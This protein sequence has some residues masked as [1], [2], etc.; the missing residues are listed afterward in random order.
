MTSFVDT[1]SRSR[2]S[3]ENILHGVVLVLALAILG[4]LAAYLSTGV[5]GAMSVAA[6]AIA[7]GI[8]APAAPADLT[9]RLYRA[10]P[11][12]RDDSQLSTIVD[13][14]SERAGLPRRPDLFVVPSLTLNA[15]SAGTSDRPA[16]A[17]SEGMLRR[18]TMREIAALVAH[19]IAHIRAG[20]LPVLAIADGVT[21]AFQVLAYVGVLFAL[22]NLV[23]LASGGD[24][25]PWSAVVLFYLGPMLSNLL[26]L[27]LDRMREHHA[28]LDAVELTGDPMGLASAV[29]RAETYRGHLWEDLMLPVPG[30]RS[31]QPSMLRT[32]PPQEARVSRLLALGRQAYR[33]PVIISEKPMVSL[34]GLGPIEL[35]PRYRFPGLW[36]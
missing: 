25:W 11:V 1:Q 12:P 2:Q 34:V 5:A 21:R 28:D 7:I 29:K 35:R 19:E 23:A 13:V 30:R 4:G 17:L 24:P 16:I 27:A 14:F 33:E 8:A 22:L 36:Y 6:L 15:F 31:P 20:D 3:R 26:Q 10:I 32:H 9:M 18:L